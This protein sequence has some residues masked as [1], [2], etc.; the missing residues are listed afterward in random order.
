M[1]AVENLEELFLSTRLLRSDPFE[2]PVSAEL[3]IAAA[4]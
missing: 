1:G 2:L 3:R 4:E